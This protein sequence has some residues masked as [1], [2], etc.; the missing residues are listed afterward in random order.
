MLTDPSKSFELN[1]YFDNQVRGETSPCSIT[2]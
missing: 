1:L 2:Y